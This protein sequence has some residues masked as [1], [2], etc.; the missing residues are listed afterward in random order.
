MATQTRAPTLAD[1]QRAARKAALEAE[2]AQIRA[3]DGDADT[4]EGDGD[5]EVDDTDPTTVEEPPAAEPGAEQ[6]PETVSEEVADASIASVAQ[7][8][9][10]SASEEAKANPAM[11]LS[12]ISAGLTLD[13]FRAMAA[14]APPAASRSPL[15]EAMS[16]N[17]R[18]GPDASRPAGGSGSALVADAKK[19]AGVAG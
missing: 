18:L 7:F 4:D 19:R 16:G 14:A 13:Q 10:I 6:G 9:A 12:A 2:L 11:A 3:Q 5:G 8:Q 17:R 1:A 15:R